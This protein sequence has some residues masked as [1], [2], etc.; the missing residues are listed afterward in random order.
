MLDMRVDEVVQLVKIAIDKAPASE[1]DKLSKEAS[2]D[3]NQI[4]TA[5]YTLAVNNFYIVITYDS[6]NTYVTR[7]ISLLPLYLEA[8]D[9]DPQSKEILENT[10]FVIKECMKQYIDEETEH[11]IL[12]SESLLEHLQNI[13][14]DSEI[15]LFRL[16]E[17]YLPLHVASEDADKETLES[18]ISQSVDVNA[19]SK[20]GNTPLHL[21]SIKSHKQIIEILITKG[22]D[23]NARNNDGR[24][25]LFL[26]CQKGYKDIIELLALNGA[27]VNLGDNT[28]ENPLLLICNSGKRGIAEILI[29]R[30]ADVNIQ[31]KNGK[32]PLYTACSRGHREII[33]LLLAK[34][35]DIYGTEAYNPIQ[36]AKDKGYKDIAQILL[37]HKKA[38]LSNKLEQS[39]HFLNKKTSGTVE[40]KREE[41]RFVIASVFIAFILLSCFLFF[42]ISSSNNAISTSFFDAVKVGQTKKVKDLLAKRPSLVTKRDK[43]GQTPL[44]LACRSN[45]KKMVELLISNGADLNARSD[46]GWTPL[47]EASDRGYKEIEKLLKKHGAKE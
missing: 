17:N 9:Y 18:L 7:I 21:A 10:I 43:L 22:A 11:S 5:L 37:S 25:P 24:T 41:R 16:N 26:A 27:D 32:T 13:L 14:T 19:R 12:L 6:F 2:S 45:Q 29:S 34:G 46:D 28:G 20:S 23:T 44:H 8:S 40:E 35:A 30:G 4:A 33:D 3:L 31:D 42:I 36:I 39:G 47:H 1:K 15:N 38:T